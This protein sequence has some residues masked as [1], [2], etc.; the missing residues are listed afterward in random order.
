MTLAIESS[1][2]DRYSFDIRQMSRAPLS[3]L[4]LGSTQRRAHARIDRAYGAA[5]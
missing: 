5:S 2:D 3:A 1:Y 4:I